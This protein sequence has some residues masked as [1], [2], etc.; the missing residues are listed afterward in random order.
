MRP[1]SFL[2]VSNKNQ[3]RSGKGP[4]KLTPY[5]QKKQ[6]ETDNFYNNSLYISTQKPIQNQGHLRIEESPRCKR[7]RPSYQENGMLKLQ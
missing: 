4:I 1:K 2:Q 5:M 7:G 3:E 6:K